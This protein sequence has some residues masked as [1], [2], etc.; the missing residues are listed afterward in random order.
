VVGVDALLVLPVDAADATNAGGS[1]G[2]AAASVVSPAAGTG[3]EDSLFL[4]RLPT[5]F[6]GA[7]FM[8]S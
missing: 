1:T 5:G 8:A 3:G 6:R 4:L 2:A 7:F